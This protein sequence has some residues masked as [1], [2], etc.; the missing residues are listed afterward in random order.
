MRS[1]VVNPEILSWTE[2]FGRVTNTHTKLN[3]HARA[4]RAVGLPPA[5]VVFVTRSVGSDHPPTASWS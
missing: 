3:L 1:L 2:P 4:A 5:A